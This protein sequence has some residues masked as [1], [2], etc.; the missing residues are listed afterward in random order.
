MD[1]LTLSLIAAGG[2]AIGSLPDIIPSAA[3]RDQKKELDKL[4]RRQEQDLLGL[5]TQ[6]RSAIE[7][8]L[9]TKTQSQFDAAQAQRNRLLAG[10]MGVGGGDKLLAD[11]AM[12]E[13]QGRV[14]AE[15]AQQVEMADLARAREEEQMI[16]DLQATQGEY[17]RAR[18]DALASIPT[19]GIGAYVGQ[20]APE[21]LLKAGVGEGRSFAAEAQGI[22]LMMQEFGLNEGQARQQLNYLKSANP[23]LYKFYTNPETQAYMS[24]IGGG[25]Q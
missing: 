5:T 21:A 9:Q 2:Q 11:A 12:S 6:E 13:A 14:A 1:P 20:M 19:A 25:M 16:R 8:Q 17:A 23:R 18:A 15:A 3:E 7:N 4:K 24:M 22:G 10:G